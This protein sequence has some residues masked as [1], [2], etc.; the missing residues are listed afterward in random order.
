MARGSPHTHPPPYGRSSALR[1]WSENDRAPSAPGCRLARKGAGHWH[2]SC[3]QDS[4]GKDEAPSPSQPHLVR[5]CLPQHGRL[6]ALR[7]RWTLYGA[8]VPHREHKPRR[9]EA[10]TLT[11]QACHFRRSRP[12][13]ERTEQSSQ[14]AEL[15]RL[16]KNIQN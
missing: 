7:S 1:R 3:A 12:G 4:R 5:Q 9:P 8:E 6:A 10:V 11:Q 14:K 13:R 15:V 16:D 2:F